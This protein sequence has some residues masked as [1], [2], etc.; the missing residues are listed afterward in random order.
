MLQIT[1]LSKSYG[2]KHAVA[3]I[4]LSVR[5]GEIYGFLGP[6]GAGKTTTIKMLTGILRPDSG[7]ILIDGIDLRAEPLAAKA[8]MAYVPD[9]PDV[10]KKLKG[11]EYVNFMA[12]MYSVPKEVRSELIKKYAE[13]FEMTDA[14]SSYIATYS[15]GM[16]QKIVLIGALVTQ[17][18]V[19]ILDEPM[20]GLDPKS[21]FNLK[22]LMR[23]LCAEGKTVF[24][25][26]HVLDVAEKFC[27]R[28][29]IIKNGS[30]IAE[31]SLSELRTREGS[32]ASLE[33]IFLELTE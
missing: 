15:H 17:P 31:G 14:L 23:S 3:D 24:F 21:S 2:D 20:V 33:Q 26:T 10:A 8:R 7:S 30:I 9:T 5:S 27:D 6:N 19:L 28:V 25:S 18:N 12:D 16:Q 13:L 22:E 11:I 4:S 1:N 32:G 29:G